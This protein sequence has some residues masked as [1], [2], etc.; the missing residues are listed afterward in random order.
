M[1]KI[2]CFFILLPIFIN[3]CC[4][5]AINDDFDSLIDSDR[6]QSALTADEKEIVGTPELDGSYDWKKSLSRLYEKIIASLSEKLKSELGYGV[7]LVALAMFCAVANCFCTDKSLSGCINIA[8]CCAAALMLAGDTD[9]IIKQAVDAML[10]LSDYSKAAIPAIF[11]A[12]A[13]TGAV[14]SSAAKY[15]A[16]SLVIDLLIS[17]AVNYI[18][19]LIN[20]YLSISITRS[21]FDNSILS[22]FSRFIKWG[23]TTFMTVM[24][25]AF[26]AY[27][28]F[29]GLISGSTDML[30]VKTTRTI[31]SN[32]LPVV[33]KLIS[34]ASSVILAGANIVKNSAGVYS[35]I[36]VCALCAS[37]F[38][39][40]GI[41]MLVFKAAASLAD[42]LPGSKLSGLINDI[43]TAF[44][45][46]LGLVGCCGIMLFISIISG[47]RVIT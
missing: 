43:G 10:Q 28:A 33:G 7:K 24:T 17:T 41:K 20:L 16:S 27:I 29:T 15:A 45:M 23:A 12:A 47:I 42:M 38:I 19:P 6:L 37:P 21:I 44:G 8:A 32:S 11:T 13:A 36:A 14:A 30:A 31:I 39:S 5:F 22:A 40:L 9:S 34:D 3:S 2:I 26:T 46:L 25:M 1:R 35:L 18:V 4:A